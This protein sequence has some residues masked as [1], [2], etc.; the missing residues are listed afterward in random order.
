MRHFAE[1]CFDPS[2]GELSHPNLGTVNLR[3][4]T[5]QLLLY[6]LDHPRSVLSQERLIH[7]VWGTTSIS[8]NVLLQSIRELR[9]H[10]GDDAQEPAFIKTHAKRGYAW[11]AP[12]APLPRRWIFPLVM[13]VVVLTWILWPSPTR[14]DSPHRNIV[15]VP[16]ENATGDPN[17]M[18]VEHGL[19]DMLG[20]ALVHHLKADVVPS[21]AVETQLAQTRETNLDQIRDLFGVSYAIT[22]RIERTEPYQATMT[23]S[24][25]NGS[26]QRAVEG[27]ELSAFVHELTQSA[28]YLL[29]MDTPATFPGGVSQVS[30][31]NAAYAKGI[32]ALRSEGAAAALQHFEFAAIV[33][34]QFLWPVMQ[35]AKACA[36][37]GHMD[38][39]ETY[40]KQVHR[41]AFARDPNL[42]VT[43][44][45]EW[46]GLAIEQG[47]MD[48]AE[49]RLLEAIADAQAQGYNYGLAQAWLKQAYLWTLK[50]EWERA[51]SRYR[52]ALEISHH[53]KDS[54]M[55][56]QSLLG[57]AANCQASED[58]GPHERRFKQALSHYAQTN[59]QRARA[60]TEMVYAVMMPLG[61]EEER[62]L[63]LHQSQVTY[64]KLADVK[65]LAMVDFARGY[66][67][68]QQ[69]NPALASGFLACAVGNNPLGPRSLP[70]HE[71]QRLWA[72]SIACSGV[73]LGKSQYITKGAELLEAVAQT[74]RHIEFKIG[75]ATCEFLL[76]RLFTETGDYDRA[77]SS[78][79]RSRLAFE[80][81]GMTRVMAYIDL[82][83]GDLQMRQHAWA[84]AFAHLERANLFFDF[85]DGLTLERMARCQYELGDLQRALDLQSK[86]VSTPARFDWK[87]CESREAH[88]RAALRG[89]PVHPLGDEPSFLATR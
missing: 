12:N 53:L 16:F 9:Q 59:N 87:P 58:F 83:L 44:L 23:V 2:T 82:Q 52:E 72:W 10:L 67:A 74:Y 21:Y 27:L 35:A 54:H 29:G 34:P 28:A 39:A 63:L 11:I 30:E 70:E 42:S 19:S 69:N 15:V 78:L 88:Y 71:A 56:A 13:A 1:F 65:G 86:A 64:R 47:A 6:F 17:V 22:A 75:V 76:G 33:D 8:S 84:E 36:A 4:K 25:P 61:R 14:R 41:H 49:D 66:Q 55:E 3:P 50:G 51:Q 43:C 18:W 7:A 79:S 20:E 80:R 24:G 37:M 62:E 89:E 81:T 48:T 68:L 26:H 38:Q 77:Q 57:M 85:K 73:Q 5:A 60:M 46:A 32:E 31:A 45:T 40:F